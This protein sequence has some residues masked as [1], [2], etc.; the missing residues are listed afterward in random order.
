MHLNWEHSN[1]AHTHATKPQRYH[2][3]FFA[4]F[5]RRNWTFGVFGFRFRFL[6]LL[7]VFFSLAFLCILFYRKQQT[8]N[9]LCTVIS[10]FHFVERAIY[11]LNNTLLFA[12][13]R[14]CDFFFAVF[15][16]FSIL[17]LFSLNFL[18]ASFV[19]CFFLF[20][21]QEMYFIYYFFAFVLRIYGMNDKIERKMLYV[22]YMKKTVSNQNPKKNKIT[23]MG[24]KINFPSDSHL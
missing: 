9:N 14:K 12:D 20:L 2:W 17:N 1:Q 18:L 22:M 15:V 6:L 23:K 8:T 11:N 4:H 24:K 7:M 21:L 13:Q 19:L 5:T 3:H 16:L 10:S